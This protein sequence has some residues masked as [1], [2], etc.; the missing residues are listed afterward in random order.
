MSRPGTL[1]WF[2]RH[3]LRLG[4]RDWTNLMTAGRRRTG[5]VALVL[6]GFV[7]F[8]H[9]LAY[10]M[11]GR[12]AA[13]AP[14][15]DLPTLMFLE[16]MALLYWSLM[17]SQAMESVTRAFYARADLDLLL[18]APVQSRRVFAVR[19]AAIAVMVA[20]MGMLVVA[21]FANVLAVFGGIGWL[22]AYPVA[23]ALGASAVA[24]AV[25]L[26]V[27][28]FRLLGPKRTRLVAQIVAAVFGAAFVISLQIAAIGS[29]G[30]FDRMPVLHSPAL[31]ARAPDATSLLWLPAKAILGDP[32]A[33]AALLVGSLM[34]LLLAAAL[35]SRRFGDHA[36]AAAG[37]AWSAARPG[38]D[39]II[40][41]RR[42]GPRTKLRH[43]EWRLLRRDPW[44][45]SQS[46]M[47]IIYLLP[48]VYLLWQNFGETGTLTLIVPVLVM[49]AG[50]L[51]GGLAWIT[52]SGE[53]APDLVTSAPITRRQMIRAK[54]EAV[55]GALAMV[56]APLL[57]ALAVASPRSAFVAVLGIVVAASAAIA[58]QL[59]FAVQAKRS[60]FRR[61]HTSSR[62]ATFAETF[63][64][65]L[66]AG[67]AGAVAVG[68]WLA[69]VPAILAGA[70]V[71]GAW[72]ISPRRAPG[73]AATA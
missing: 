1:F 54:V 60:H 67:T 29:Y 47:Q 66:W 7:A 57:L 64:S 43:K 24:A 46:L 22:S 12:F 18:S 37:V 52:V 51:A 25:A 61:R 27:G 33:L 63:S 55:F 23:A 13:D 42:A 10:S 32:A 28:L 62:I 50:Q 48:P 73:V 31:L 26:T 58:I 69:I 44:L 56:L 14:V 8:M 70:V 39:G 71:V 36:V 68:T 20:T 65:L 6:L 72:A 49:A 9:L 30:T 53:D 35:F 38:A 19:I 15:P 17:L 34:L 2:A 21:P 4:W 40:R 3:E 41:F 11:V 16:A 59:W 45:L 5:T